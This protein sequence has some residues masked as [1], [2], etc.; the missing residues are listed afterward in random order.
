M[1]IEHSLHSI[2]SNG[3]GPVSMQHGFVETLDTGLMKPLSAPPALQHLQ[4]PAEGHRRHIHHHS[5]PAWKAL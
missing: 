1:R 2:V 4:I 5:S 3:A